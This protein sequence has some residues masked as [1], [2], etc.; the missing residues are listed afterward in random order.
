MSERKKKQTFTLFW[1]DWCWFH[2]LFVSFID[3]H[4]WCLKYVAFA[5]RA[6]VVRLDFEGLLLMCVCACVC[7]CGCVLVC[8]HLCSIIFSN[9]GECLCV[10]VMCY[11]RNK[12]GK[13]NQC[14][15]NPL[16]L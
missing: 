14:T 16:S 1:G 10:W 12:R 15:E 3:L 13:R 7:L 8:A 6:W 4:N 2:W 9:V 11:T 5:S